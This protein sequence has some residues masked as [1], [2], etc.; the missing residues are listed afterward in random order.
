LHCPQ[1][2]NQPSSWSNR[3]FDPVATLGLIPL[4]NYA[5]VAD[6]AHSIGLDNCADRS[7]KHPMPVPVSLRKLRGFSSQILPTVYQFVHPENCAIF[8]S[9]PSAAQ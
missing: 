5:K 9:R 2:I 7:D 8:M 1:A 3:E 6:L 4:K